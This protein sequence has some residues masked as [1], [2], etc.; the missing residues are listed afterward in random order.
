MDFFAA[1]L[2]RKAVAGDRVGRH[3][4]RVFFSATRGLRCFPPDQPA[5]QGSRPPDGG[6][7]SNSG[8]EHVCQN[9]C[10]LTSSS[11]K[12][13]APPGSQRVPAPSAVAQIVMDYLAP[14]L[15]G[16]G[17]CAASIPTH[18]NPPKLTAG[19]GLLLRPCGGNR[20]EE[21]CGQKSRK[22]NGLEPNCLLLPWRYA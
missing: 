3:T 9:C 14:W 11:R 2:F 1:P 22:Y 10:M 16:R 18:S 13:E 7:G 15:V 6:F 5:P 4:H 20:T 21:N 8:G 19:H 12:V 17:K